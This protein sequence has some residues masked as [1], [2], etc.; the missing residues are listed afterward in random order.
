M[1]LAKQLGNAIAASGKTQMQIAEDAAVGQ[2][3]ISR[4]LVGDVSLNYRNIRKLCHALPDFCAA[5]IADLTKKS[6]ARISAPR[7]QARERT[8]S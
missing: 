2:A 4:F 1:T 8:T 5:V 6:A 3:T 7:S